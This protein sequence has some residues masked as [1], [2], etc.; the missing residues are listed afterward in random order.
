MLTRFA[1]FVAPGAIPGRLLTVGP[2]GT[3]NANT[4]WQSTTAASPTVGTT[5]ITFARVGGL[6]GSQ[7]AVAG[8]T[9]DAITADFTPNVALVDGLQV[10]VRAAFA[11]ATTA[12][13]LAVD[14]GSAI[15]VKKNGNQT[16]SVGDIRAVGHELLLR[17][18]EST[19]RWELLNPAASGGGAWGTIT[20]TLSDQTD[21]KSALDA[22][23]DASGVTL[24]GRVATYSAL[25]TSG[26]TAGNAYLVDADSLVYVW[27]GSAFPAN[28]SGLSVSGSLVASA[29]VTGSA[30][31][32]LT[33]TGLDLNAHHDYRILVSG[34][35]N[36][37]SSFDAYL[38]F[39]GDTTNANYGRQSLYGLGSTAGAAR[40]TSPVFGTVG[41]S[42]D[43]DLVATMVKS[44]SGWPAV[45]GAQSAGFYTGLTHTNFV[46][47]RNNSANVT[48]LTYHASVA[49]ALAIGT[50]IKVYRR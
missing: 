16:L 3:A 7:F 32:D 37:A 48:S 8:G 46:I 44:P 35:N 6:G 15:A 31:T 20:G 23:A 14:S 4:A 21:L 25:P 27:N 28:G 38:Y 19:P 18:V 33:V 39:N 13:T 10:R 2:L 34:K 26:L 11:N 5:S 9:A 47:R 36:N 17:Y 24:S 45:M 41:A 43:F 50:E 29:V 1:R 40:S 30:A 22:K 12:P 42:S 49:G